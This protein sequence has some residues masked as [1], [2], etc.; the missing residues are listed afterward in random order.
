MADDNTLATM[1]A[2]A[3]ALQQLAL[4]LH[5]L[6]DDEFQGIGTSTEEGELEYDEEIEADASQIMYLGGLISVAGAIS[7][8]TRSTSRG[9]YNQFQKC[10]DWFVLSLQWPDRQFRHEYR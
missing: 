8:S 9:P 10:T 3:A 7:P 4:S 6:V 1:F 5:L 2:S